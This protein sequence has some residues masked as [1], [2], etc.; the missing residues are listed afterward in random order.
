MDV[1]DLEGCFIRQYC[2]NLIAYLVQSHHANL[3]Q[4][5]SMGVGGATN[6]YFVLTVVRDISAKQKHFR[7]SPIIRQ[8]ILT[9]LGGFSWLWKFPNIR[10][11]SKCWNFTYGTQIVKQ[12]YVMSI[13]TKFEPPSSKITPPL[14][15]ANILFAIFI[16]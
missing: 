2:K 7:N 1:G 6:F 10:G 3:K 14:T 9:I 16:H 13:F 15:L 4:Q 5:Q 8:T 11:N 12:G